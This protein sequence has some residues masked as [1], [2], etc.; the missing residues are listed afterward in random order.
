VA[1]LKRLFHVE[2]IMVVTADPGDFVPRVEKSSRRSP[3]LP[4]EGR[5]GVGKLG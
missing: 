4:D 2:T 5:S 1:P 3:A